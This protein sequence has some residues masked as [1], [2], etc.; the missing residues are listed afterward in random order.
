MNNLIKCAC[1]ETP[2]FEEDGNYEICSI[3]NW[4]NDPVQNSD[5]NYS[6]GANKLSLNKS[7][8]EYSK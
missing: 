2:E 8:E 5:P 3:C 1:C 4:Q 7:K 6:G